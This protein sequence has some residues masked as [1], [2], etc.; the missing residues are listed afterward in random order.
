[1]QRGQRK[2][3]THVNLEPLIGELLDAVAARMGEDPL[4]PTPSRS[5]LLNKAARLY[6]DQC[7]T[8]SELKETIETI[9]S[10]FL[11]HS[12]NVLQYPKATGRTRRARTSGTPRGAGG[13]PRGRVNL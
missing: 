8:R 9:E 7:K 13:A 6:L 2:L 10:R 4:Y 12:P 11:S 5:D 1:M 3:K